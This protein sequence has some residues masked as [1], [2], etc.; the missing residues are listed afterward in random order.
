MMP[1]IEPVI[2]EETAQ[3]IGRFIDLGVLALQLVG[4]VGSAA[5]L[6]WVL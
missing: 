5:V 6:W 1:N 3:W 2:P 4:L